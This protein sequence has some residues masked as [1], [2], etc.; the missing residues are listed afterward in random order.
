MEM[1]TAGSLRDGQMVWASPRVMVG[2]TLELDV[3]PQEAL[4]W[5]QKDLQVVILILLFRVVN[6]TLSS[7]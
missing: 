7:H 5:A 4:M 3:R 1:H 2:E 6:H